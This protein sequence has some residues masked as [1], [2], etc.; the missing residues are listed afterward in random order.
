MEKL[1]RIDNDDIRQISGLCKADVLFERQLPC[2]GGLAVH[3][4]RN[5]Q[6]SRPVS[7]KGTRTFTTQGRR[8]H[9]VAMRNRFIPGKPDDLPFWG[10]VREIMNYPHGL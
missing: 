3:A 7:A 5:H 2:V 4:H 9:S 1:V 6:L 8:E 10:T